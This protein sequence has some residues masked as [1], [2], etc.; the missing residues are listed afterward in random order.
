MDSSGKTLWA[1]TGIN[2]AVFL[3]WHVEKLRSYLRMDRNFLVSY[4][5]IVKR[6]DY[7]T[8]RRP[9]FAP[10]HAPPRAQLVGACFSHQ[11]ISH[12]LGNMTSMWAVG[13]VLHPRIGARIPFAPTAMPLLESPQVL[14]GLSR[15]TSS[16]APAQTLSTCCSAS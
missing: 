8:V 5:A 7:R 4:A 1:L 2:A 12:F 13:R 3:S 14:R 6:K 10:A 15:C 16:R 9:G 11:D